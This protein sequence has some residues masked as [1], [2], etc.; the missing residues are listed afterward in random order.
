M[1]LGGICPAKPSSKFFGNQ[2]NCPIRVAD[3]VNYYLLKL[4]GS[5]VDLELLPW[6]TSMITVVIGVLA[7]LAISSPSQRA[8]QGWLFGREI[9][10]PLSQSSEVCA[11]PHTALSDLSVCAM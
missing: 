4:S 3:F 2:G 7:T 5:V 9:V 6:S 1:V 10:T 11:A 8:K